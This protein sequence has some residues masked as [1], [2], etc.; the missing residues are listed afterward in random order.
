MPI[1]AILGGVGAIAD[2]FVGAKNYNL[3]KNALAWQKEAQETTWAREDNAVQRRAEDLKQAGLS[4]V[5]AAGSAAQTSGPIT[6]IVPQLKS[7]F[8]EKALMAQQ[9]LTQKAVYDKTLAETQLAKT[10]E[11]KEKNIIEM[12]AMD[13]LMKLQDS[14]R[15]EIENQRANVEL[16]QKQADYN[17]YN[18]MGVP[19]DSPQMVKTGA[20]IANSG[21]IN[22]KKM[23]SLG[24]NKITFPMLSY[25]KDI[26]MPVY[27]SFKEI[28]EK[29]GGIMTSAMYDKLSKDEKLFWDN[30]QYNKQV[31]A[32]TSN[33]RLNNALGVRNEKPSS[34]S[35]RMR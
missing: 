16:Q 35:S 8:Q 5:L 11:E 28:A 18:A 7:N 22:A 12:Q 21:I 15:K 23:L 29:T 10:S 19:S 17:V 25:L 2:A 31:P 3:Q 26:S 33:P 6:P 20:I 13:K 14:Q 4:P 1:G 24:F 9:A 34:S 27:N 32:V 30:Y